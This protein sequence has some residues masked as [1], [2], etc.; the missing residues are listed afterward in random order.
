MRPQSDAQLK[1]E[2]LL[3]ACDKF[4]SSRSVERFAAGVNM[5]HHEACRTMVARGFRTD[6]QLVALHRDND[7]GYSRLGIYVLDDWR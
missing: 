6:L 1:F 5:S 7:P 4:A 3:D 2:Q